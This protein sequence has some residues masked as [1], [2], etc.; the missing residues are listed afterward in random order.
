MSEPASAGPI[1]L[2]KLLA[3]A[4]VA[5]RRHSDVMIAAGKVTVDGT[6]TREQ[7][8]RVDPVTSVVRVEGVRVELRATAVHL[9]LN[10]PAGVLSAMSDDRNRPTIADYL[11]DWLAVGRLFHVGRLDVDSEGLLL[12]TNDGE[13]AHRLTHPSY[14]IRKTYLAQIGGIPD[15]GLGRRLT[16]GVDLDDGAVHV[17][18][19]SVIDVSGGAAL[20]QVVLHEGRNHVVRRLF[21]EVGHPVSRLVRTE[22]GPVRLGHQRPGTVRTLTR[23]ELGALYQL[24]GL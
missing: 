3:A 11:A 20:V 10:K 23:A 7:G 19:F 15:R 5:S 17:D 22:I 21:A 4:G 12:V 1:R 14:E 13:L 18:E 8:V 6:V 9:V 2:N 24:T 16:R